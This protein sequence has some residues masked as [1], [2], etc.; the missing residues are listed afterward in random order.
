MRVAVDSHAVHP[1]HAAIDDRLKNWARWCHGNSGRTCQPMFR[2]YRAAEHWGAH[3]PGSAVDTL[4]ATAIQKAVGVLPEVH[5]KAVSWCYVIRS[6]PRRMAEGLAV[7]MEG[8]LL[9][10]HDGR[11]MLVNRLTP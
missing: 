3:E 7:S 11:T 6:N 4:D 9:L 1:E 10:I 2:L 8:L 5:R